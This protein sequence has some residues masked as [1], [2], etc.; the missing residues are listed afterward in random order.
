M[1]DKYYVRYIIEDCHVQDICDIAEIANLWKTGAEHIECFRYYS[2]HMQNLTIHT[3]KK[4]SA[5]WL[6]DFYGNYI[7]GNAL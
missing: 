1:L 6:T 4:S 7:E 3:D 2:G 5:L